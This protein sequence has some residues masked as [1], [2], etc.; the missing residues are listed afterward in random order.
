MSGSRKLSFSDEDMKRYGRLD[1]AA[2]DL[3]HAQAYGAFILKKRWKA[4]PGAAIPRTCSSPP[5]SQA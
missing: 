3:H 4:K 2:R 5:L 1:I